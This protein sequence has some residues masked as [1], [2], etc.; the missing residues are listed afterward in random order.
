[1]VNRKSKSANFLQNGS[2]RKNIMEISSVKKSNKITKRRKGAAITWETAKY[3]YEERDIK[4]AAKE[5]N[6]K[7]NREKN[8]FH[9]CYTDK[10]NGE[11]Y[12]ISVKANI[13][14]LIKEGGIYQSV[15]SYI[16]KEKKYVLKWAFKDCT[17]KISKPGVKAEV[18]LEENIDALEVIFN[19]EIIQS[20]QS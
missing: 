18:L 15:S 11:N 2:L 9:F 5:L 12:Q 20:N 16:K 6:N 14:K 3:Y 17:V 10:L 4:R 13:W 19:D 8:K 1:M 7:L